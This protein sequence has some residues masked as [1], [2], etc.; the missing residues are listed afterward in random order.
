MSGWD[1]WLQV[2]LGAAAI[3]VAVLIWKYDRSQRSLSFAIL[4]RRAVLAEPAKGLSLAVQKD[5]VDIEDPWILVARVANGGLAPIEAAHYEQPLTFN[6]PDAKVISAEIT[7]ARP[8]GFQPAITG[9]DDHAVTFQ[10]LLMN[11][12]DMFEVQLILSGMPQDI[13]LTGRIS[14]VSKIRRYSVSTDSWGQPWNPKWWEYLVGGLP[15]IALVGMA[16]VALAA[17]ERDNSVTAFV[18]AG[19]MAIVGVIVYPFLAFRNVRK[20]RLFLSE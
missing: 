11:K 10:S 1:A 5:N 4:Y 13:G 15:A 19:C 14:G 2:I 7:K 9:I 17:G 18:M 3:L 12:S 6:V 20:A 8:S 16:Y